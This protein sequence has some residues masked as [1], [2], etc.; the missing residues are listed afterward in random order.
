MGG[1]PATGAIARTAAGIENGAKSP[2]T[3]MFHAVFV[4]VLYFALMGVVKHIPLC[5]FS[6]I[7]ISVAINMS[8]FKLFFKLTKFGIRDS[9]VLVVTCI[10]TVAFDLTYCVLGGVALA[11]ILN[12]KNF[13]LGLK[14]SVENNIIKVSGTMFFVNANKLIDCIEKNSQALEQITLDLSGVVNIDQTALEKIATLRKKLCAQEKQLEI[15]GLNTKM[16]QRVDEF[17]TVL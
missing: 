17:L 7:L 15:V 2:L 3:G 1:L 6:A 8:R 11:L 5:V 14:T 10:L 13:K 4:L 9:I 16:Q 12:C